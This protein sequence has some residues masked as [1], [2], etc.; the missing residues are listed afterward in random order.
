M[1]TLPPSPAFHSH[2]AIAPNNHPFPFLLHLEWG[3]LA[4]AIFSEFLPTP[5][6]QGQ[7]FHVITIL[8]LMGFGIVGLRLPTKQPS[9]KIWFTFLEI[10]LIGLATITGSRTLRVFPLLYLVMVIRSCLMF[11]LAGRLV[12]TALALI[13]F[14]GT[15]FHRVHFIEER[16]PP[17]AQERVKPFLG[18]FVLICIFLF[19]LAL[20]FI[21]LLINALLAE[22]QSQEKL[23]IANEQLRQSA[24]RV[25]H[26][27]MVQERN[28]IARDIHD[29][30]G[31]SLTALNLQLEG[32][33]KLWQTNP[34]R[35]QTVLQEAKRLG[36]T[37]LTEVRESVG[38]LRSDPLQGQSLEEA[39]ARLA[40]DF[41]QATGI[42]PQCHLRITTALSLE[43]Q[44]A[45]YRI[46]QE[47]LTNT[48]KYAGATHV[49][50]QVETHLHRV[51]LTY[52]DNGKGFDLQQN[53]TGFGLQ[54]MQERTLALSGHYQ[55][56]TA[57]GEG[58]LIEA[59]VPFNP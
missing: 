25:E 31:H 13:A 18:G 15:L 17:L 48:C 12:V 11:K 55:L 10:V 34:V 58:C 14:I 19:G 27:A 59:S 47:A 52:R 44:M 42:Q 49:H 41:R 21:L 29:A 53:R 3:L 20:I 7:R 32:A 23:A 33:L 35:A 37:A 28:R 38:T 36:S 5:L 9:H 40:E 24:R 26:L 45:L 43:I 16:L 54:G 57:L 56:T 6:F 51:H 4:I 39:I 2:S 1:S 46:V 50:I 22:R 8:S 30:L